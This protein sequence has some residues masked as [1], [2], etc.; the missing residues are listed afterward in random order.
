MVINRESG[1]FVGQLSNYRLCKKELFIWSVNR[2]RTEVYINCRA[3]VDCNLTR[4][5]FYL[6]I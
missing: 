3:N 2:L 6:E 1:E 4:K 5:N